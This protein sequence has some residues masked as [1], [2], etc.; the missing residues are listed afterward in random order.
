MRRYMNRSITTLLI[1][2]LIVLIGM[3]TLSGCTQDKQ[4]ETAQTQK[5]PQKPEVIR[6]GA[7]LP[8]TG[9]LSFFGEEER[10]ALE[11]FEKS[12]LDV[13]F[14]FEDSK[15]TPK[16]GL[17]AA[18]KLAAQGIKYYISSLSFIVNTIQPVFDREKAANFTLNMDPRSEEKSQYMLRLYVTFYDEMDKLIELAKEKEA[19]RIAVLYV[20]VETM[21]NAVE[22]YLRSQL[23]PLNIELYAEAYDIGNKDFRP[24][25]LKISDKNLD[26]LRILDFGDK[27]G[28]VLKQIGE[29]K[30]LADVTLVS[31]I[32]TLLSNYSEFPPELMS[33]FVFTIPKFLLDESNP[34]VQQY[35]SKY[36]SPPSFDALFAYD[37]ASLLVPAIRKHGYENVDEVIEAI[38]SMKEY[39]GSAAEYTINEKGG[40]SPN[41]YWAKIESGKVKFLE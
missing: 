37:V 26:I 38:T 9:E 28:V 39:T 16:D 18:N 6:I 10:K 31:G 17:S 33:R 8:M 21:H 4:K 36:G 13:E 22:N 32:E 40:V 12:N 1:A 29:S 5:E 15:G 24:L 30:S 41:T 7:V 20:N 2:S 19:K 25:V 35:T 34:V 27:L 3:I 23:Q 11:L 14:L